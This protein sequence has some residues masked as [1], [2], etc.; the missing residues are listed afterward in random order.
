VTG[1]QG[2]DVKAAGSDAKLCPNR[3]PMTVELHREVVG[4]RE[5]HTGT[6]WYC[7]ECDHAE[8][9]LSPRA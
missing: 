4:S 3:H 8:F 5:G 6:L 9:E 7:P 1:G 2:I